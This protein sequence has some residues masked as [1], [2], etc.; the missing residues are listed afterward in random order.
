LRAPIKLS[1]SRIACPKCSAKIAVPSSIVN[2]QVDD[3]W[4]SLDGT[5]PS[6]ESTQAI[7]NPLPIKD[8][9]TSLDD[10]RQARD[11][12]LSVPKTRSVFE[13]DLPDLV[14]M[15]ET[16]QAPTGT[17]N[18]PAPVI[19]DLSLPDIDLPELAPLESVD[20]QPLEP[21][22]TANSPKE[23]KQS[24]PEM[25]FLDDDLPELAPLDEN[26][27]K[28]VRRGTSGQRANGQKNKQP[29]LAEPIL[30]A[31]A[32][33]NDFALPPNDEFRFA[34]KTCGTSLY[35][36]ESRVGYT[37]R[38]P[39]CY[40]EQSIPKPFRKAK[41]PEL[42]MEDLPSVEL[43]PIDAKSV[44]TFVPA[45]ADDILE[46]AAQSVDRDKNDI[47][48]YSASFDTKRWLGLLFGFLRDPNVIAVI[49][50]LGVLNGLTFL[51]IGAIGTW[52]RLEDSTQVV[53]ARAALI[54][55]VGIPLFIFICLCGI[56]VLSMSANRTDRVDQWPL[57]RLGEAMGEGLLVF[58]SLLIACVPGGMLGAAM[59]AM[60]AHPVFSPAML[61]LSIWALTPLLLLSMIDN[62]SVTEPYSKAIIASIKRYADAW[63]A[64]YMQTAIAFV[65][66]FLMTLL[67]FSIGPI[68]ALLL[69]AVTPLLAFFLFSQ[70]GVLA[71]RISSATQLGFEGDFSDDSL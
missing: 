36:L 48:S 54:I 21:K 5:G 53:I 52:V 12:S 57:S 30:E 60:K 11:I 63:G 6:S 24:L 49:I 71:G 37:I 47:D 31:N 64:M 58:A 44:K 50:V 18:A 1:G 33:G 16:D 38:C 41:Q 28:A 40:S 22:S 67:A 42:S 20:L 15:E 65:G 17:R 59:S 8:A 3:E 32:L 25:P 13:D 29:G 62:G 4:L 26:Q 35:A 55:V 51:A 2:S 7:E 34:C 69:G 61:F 56:S 45:N 39:D 66:L 14:L 43:K 23:R 9:M 70:Y 10:S 19:L 46:K 68:G 27:A